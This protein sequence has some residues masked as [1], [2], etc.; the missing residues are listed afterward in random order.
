MIQEEVDEVF[1]FGGLQEHKEWG[2]ENIEIDLNADP[3]LI[4]YKILKSCQLILLT[5]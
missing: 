1:E 2:E 5:I 3:A 4:D